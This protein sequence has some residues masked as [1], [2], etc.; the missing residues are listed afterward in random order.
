MSWSGSRAHGQWRLNRGFHHSSSCPTP[1]PSH[2]R[3]HQAGQWMDSLMYGASRPKHLSRPA[4]PQNW[5]NPAVNAECRHPRTVASLLGPSPSTLHCRRRLANFP[6]GAG[7]NQHPQQDESAD[8]GHHRAH[9]TSGQPSRL[10][11]C[12]HL[13]GQFRHHGSGLGSSLEAAL[14]SLSLQ[15]NCST[16]AVPVQQLQRFPPIARVY[17][18]PNNWTSY[19]E[20]DGPFEII[21][22]TITGL[23]S[24]FARW[25][26]QTEKYLCQ[27][28]QKPT[29]GRGSNIRLFQAPLIDSSKPQVWKKGSAAYWERMGV[30][31]NVAQH[32][33]HPSVLHDL[34]QM[35]ERLAHHASK[36]LD[37]PH[38]VER[39]TQWTF[40]AAI[41]PAELQATVH[42]E[43]E[44]AQQQLLS[45]TNHEFREWL[46][47]AHDKGLRGLFRSL[48]QKDHCWKR[49][50]QDI[51][52][53][54]RIPAR[55]QQWGEIWKPLPAPCHIRGIQEL[56]RIAQAA[57]AQ[58][59]PVD[60]AL[61]GKLM[62]KLPNKA[63]GPDGISY[64]FLR[65][66]P[67]PA[68]S[69]LA[70]LLTEMERSA[71][72]PIQLRHTNIVMIPKNER[73]ERPIAL[74][75]CLYRLWN[76]YRKHEL[77]RWQLSLDQDMPWDF[78]RP[79]KDCLSIAVGRMLKAEIGKHQH[80]DLFGRPHLL[81]R[82]SAA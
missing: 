36:Q 38:F 5:R 10:L 46:E 80:C 71:E 64:D 55:E 66:L 47:K 53:T 76:S 21:G 4:L 35:L 17:Q 70:S 51:P 18:L 28:L 32:K 49:P 3:L 82:H 6:G 1:H 39:L 20:D 44:R 58:L 78:A 65:H 12:F 15:L 81:L 79:H 25:A 45:A 54:Q 48:R 27:T 68:V 22:Q 16:G 43:Q 41:D 30:R 13:S 72:L 60:T 2:P 33:R 14:C 75:S 31:I 34:R 59:P 50:F 57:A 77:H 37:Q 74:T 69:R 26:T 29:T 62:R 52:H 23:G 11:P 40:G 63:A 61:L 73:I 8:C 24:D 19:N 67:Y 42:Q 7:G 56:R 9:D